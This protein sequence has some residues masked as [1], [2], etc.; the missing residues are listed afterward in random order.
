MTGRLKVRR[1]EPIFLKTD[2]ENSISFLKT[3]F[4][5]VPKKQV[6]WSSSKKSNADIDYVRIVCTYYI[7]SLVD[8]AH[9]LG[10]RRL[11]KQKACV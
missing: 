7:R 6:L 10:Y 3:A 9:W 2:Y 11:L 4:P 5:T 8:R 1:Q